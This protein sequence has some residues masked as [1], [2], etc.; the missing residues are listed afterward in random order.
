[1]SVLPSCMYVYHVHVWYL[2]KSLEGISYELL[3]GCWELNPDP[4]QEQQVF[5]TAEPALQPQSNVAQV[6]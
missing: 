2:R 4:P 6:G 5:S 1:M 3:C